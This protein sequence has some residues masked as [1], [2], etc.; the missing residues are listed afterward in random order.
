MYFDEGALACV[1]GHAFDIA[2]QGFVNMLVGDAQA[3][4]A[5]TVEM[6]QA[7]QRFLESGL[8]EPLSSAVVDAVLEYLNEGASTG[9]SGTDG[10]GETDGSDA[11]PFVIADIGAGVGYYLGRVLE[12]A[13]QADMAAVGV[14][15]DIS[16]R[17]IQRAAKVHPRVGALVA[18][19]WAR[20]PLANNSVDVVLDIFAPRNGE[21]FARILK[22]G[23]LLVVVTPRTGHMAE[24]RE[25]VNTIKVS[26]SKA[27]ELDEKLNPYF[28]EI[29]CGELTESLVMT[30]GQ[31]LDLVMMGP[32]AHHV[33][34]TEVR[35][36]LV[37]LHDI[38]GSSSFT[39][40]MAID[41][42]T[43]LCRA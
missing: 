11:S 41:V 32:N 42:R 30:D 15:T 14:A 29:A 18:D 38:T 31:V 40:T 37:R 4:T 35:D 9:D 8:Y 21:E 16:K 26:S 6:I 27:A 25:V 2:R 13:D 24:I 3:S 19:T 1:N 28:A 20:I 34:E 43:Y 5:D 12:A 22:P 10:A 36:G 17:A 7:R 39:M 23:G 33:T